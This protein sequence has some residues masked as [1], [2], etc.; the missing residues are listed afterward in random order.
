MLSLCYKLLFEVSSLPEKKSIHAYRM[1]RLD[2]ATTI[3]Y[4]NNA[5]EMKVV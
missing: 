2:I 5:F 3:Y 1:D 4:F